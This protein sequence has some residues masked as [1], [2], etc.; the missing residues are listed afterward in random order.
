MTHFCNVLEAIEDTPL[1]ALTKVTDG[2]EGHR[3]SGQP[4]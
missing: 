3:N 1:I 4:R 2:L